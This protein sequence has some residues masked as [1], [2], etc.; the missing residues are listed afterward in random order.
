MADDVDKKFD[1]G[2]PAHR[3]GDL[4]DLTALP[5]QF[6]T[7]AAEVRSSF[8]LLGNKI[9]PFI[10]RVEQTLIDLSERVAAGEQRMTRVED[11]LAEIKAQLRAKKRRAKR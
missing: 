2:F 6:R 10:T 5:G 1:D 3:P 11:D 8:E 7:F 4:T 9:L